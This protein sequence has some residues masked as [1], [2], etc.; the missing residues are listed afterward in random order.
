MFVEY[1]PNPIAR[2]DTGDCVIRAIAKA[3]NI[4]WEDAYIR[5]C[6]A[7]Y[8]MGDLPNS[9]SVFGAIL[10]MHGFYKFSIP[11]DCPDCYTVEEFA[12]ENPNGIYVM[13]LG[14]HVVTVVNGNI[15]DAWDSSNRIPIYYWYKETEIENGERIYSES[16][17]LESTN[18]NMA[19]EST[20]AIPADAADAADAKSDGKPAA[21]K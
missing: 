4:S 11:H 5:L 19:S 13:G 18:S 12:K 16:G 14:G 10:R 7:G 6:V 2:T 21:N 15:Y 20:S 17:I 3:L 8:A 1:N 9:D